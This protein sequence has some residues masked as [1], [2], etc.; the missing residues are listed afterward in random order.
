MA[1]VAAAF[2]GHPSR[3]LVMAGVTG[4]N[5]KT[6]VTHLLGAVLRTAGPPHHGDRAP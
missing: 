4:T 6:T 1:R 5:G 2:Y 3:D